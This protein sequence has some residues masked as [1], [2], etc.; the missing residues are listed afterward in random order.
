VEAI[1]GIHAF[2][3][4][5]SASKRV[6]TTYH[7]GAPHFVTYKNGNTFLSPL[8]PHNALQ[9]LIQAPG[10]ELEQFGTLSEDFKLESN[11]LHVPSLS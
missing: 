7:D 5:V 4:K 8:Q 6:Y 10:E 11:P 9:T 3:A 1:L 2:I